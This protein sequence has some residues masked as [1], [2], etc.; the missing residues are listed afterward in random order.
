MKKIASIVEYDVCREK[1]GRIRFEE[2]IDH[3]AIR[4][5]VESD[6]EELGDF[7]SRDDAV[8]KF[9]SEGWEIECEHSFDVYEGCC[10]DAAV[11]VESFDS[12]EDAEAF[13]T[14]KGY[15]FEPKPCDDWSD[16]IWQTYNDDMGDDHGETSTVVAVYSK[17]AE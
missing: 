11:F 2:Y 15:S 5:S 13:L 1:N 4:C 16:P 12:K 6:E 17:D 14:G 8:L 3:G 9:R 7:E 10:T